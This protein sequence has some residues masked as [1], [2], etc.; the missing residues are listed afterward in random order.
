MARKVLSDDVKEFIVTQLARMEPPSA[1]IKLVKEEFGLDLTRQ[2]VN[3]YNPAT[4]DGSRL[5]EKWKVLFAK[6]R[7]AHCENVYDVAV[8]H[9]AIRLG[10]LQR[11]A[12]KAEEKGNLVLAAQLLKQAAEDH[13]GVYT[14][15]HRLEHTGKDGGP[16]RSTQ[17]VDLSKLT[18]DE[19]TAYRTVSAA[20]ARNRT[21]DQPQA[22][23]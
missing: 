15:K 17:T 21:G 13:G 18:D 4:R 5:S 11:M 23:H 20:A 2:K 22:V 14:N 9:V 1:V 12:M 6:A 10:W 8:S 7:K 16:I 19:L 3:S